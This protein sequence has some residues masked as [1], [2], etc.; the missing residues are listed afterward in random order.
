[1]TE[2]QNNTIETTQ[3]HTGPHIPKIQGE[4]VY[5]PI[6]NT[7]ITTFLFL[8]IVLVFSIFAKMALKK[9]NSKLKTAIL[10]VVSVLDKNFIESFHDKY[11][12]RAYL[13]LIG[14]I[15]FIVLFGNLFGLMIDWVGSSISPTIL[16][17]LR[18]I[19]SDLN[20]TLVLGI[21][22]VIT[23]LG[24]SLRHIG[25][26]KT[27]KGYIFNFSGNNLTE[28]IINVFVGWLHFFS[29]PATIASLS[30]RL[31]GNIFAGIVL[32]SVLSYLGVLMSSNLFE[33]GRFI[34]IPFW[35]FEVFVAFIQAIVFAGL[36]ISY[37]NQSKSHH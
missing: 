32:I 15:F 13:P 34:S 17:Y 8:I 26:G 33:I 23:F 9:D 27:V 36:M 29:V 3:E 37:F 18:P 12:A 14:G 1:M 25:I 16:H 4:I 24:I 20:T 31:F 11:F 35:F 28:K 30:L 10:D 19:S 21:I 22:T 6:S 5:G 2:T 7:N